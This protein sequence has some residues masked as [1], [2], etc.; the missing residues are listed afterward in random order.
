MPRKKKK[1]TINEEDIKK[2]KEYAEE[3]TQEI[4]IS[5]NINEFYNLLESDKNHTPFKILSIILLFI[6]GA[7]FVYKLV[8][9]DSK[10]IFTSN[11]TKIYEKLANN[12]VKVGNSEIF[13]SKYN[14]NGVIEFNSN[15]KSLQEYNNYL[16]NINFDIDKDTNKYSFNTTIEKDNYTTLDATYLISNDKNYLKLNNIYNT[17]TLDN[18]IVN[19]DSR[20]QYLLKDYD[21]QKL[22]NAIKSIKNIINK[23]I[24]K[25][26]LNKDKNT[27]TLSLS[28]E[29]YSS[30]LSKTIDEIKDNNSIINNLASTFKISNEQITKYLDK[31][32]QNNLDNNFNNLKFIINTNGL[33]YKTTSYQLLFDDKEVLYLDVDNLTFKINYNDINIDFYKEDKYKANINNNIYLTFNELNYDVIDVDYKL[34]NNIFGNIHFNK[35]NKKDNKSG[36]LI[37]S[38]VSKDIKTSFNFDYRFEQYNPVVINNPVDYKSI[39]NEDY[40]TIIKKINEQVI[41][42]PIA[43]DLINTIEKINK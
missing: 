39:S 25:Q 7:F 34:D 27:I 21:L 16:Y 22:N 3:K 14:L 20:L 13:N 42:K 15:D 2:L 23:N 37:Y 43:K 17:I 35:Y 6:V 28:K 18:S 1:N 10:F 31:I 4:K 8:I 19:L 5:H 11:I 9:S 29:E 12:L 36:K 33:F 32:L 40:S 26:Y 24:D 41:I 38:I 30:L